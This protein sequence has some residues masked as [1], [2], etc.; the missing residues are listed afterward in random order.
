MCFLIGD[1]FFRPLPLGSVFFL[2]VACPLA[3]VRG[4]GKRL[5][6]PTAQGELTRASH[7]RGSDRGPAPNGNIM[8]CCG[9]AA[10]LER[11]RR[12]HGLCY[13]MGGVNLPR[14]CVLLVAAS[15]KN[16]WQDSSSEPRRQKRRPYHT[17]GPSYRTSIKYANTAALRLAWQ[18]KKPLARMSAPSKARGQSSIKR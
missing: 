17:S 12:T 8:A 4:V 9:K 5:L 11:T 1:A 2:F 3:I 13:R 6:R 18:R 7:R 15:E 14:L 10:P 16:V